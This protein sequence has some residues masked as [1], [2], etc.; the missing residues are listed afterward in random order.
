MP[1]RGAAPGVA[2]SESSETSSSRTGVRDP[3]IQP[4]AA[5]HQCQAGTG[6]E[7]PAVGQS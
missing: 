1:A 4:P 3:H 7:P 2:T 6:R 5:G